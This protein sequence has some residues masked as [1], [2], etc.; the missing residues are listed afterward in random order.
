MGSSRGGGGRG[1]RTRVLLYLSLLWVAGGGDHCSHRPASFWASLLGMDDPTGAGSRAIRSTWTA[2][3]D[4]GFVSIESGAVS[5]DVPTI[6]PLRED[7][8]GRDYTIPAGSDGDTYRRIPQVA[9]RILFCDPDLSGPGLVTFLAMIRTHDQHRG[10]YLVL[11]RAY[12]RGE[13]GMGDSTRKAGLRNL[14]DLGVL[15]TE[16]RSTETGPAG[17]RRRGRTQYS[18]LDSYAPPR[19]EP[20]VPAP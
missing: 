12:F 15:T 8:S 17:E 9:W 1:G 11:P 14:V 20:R 6:R 13:Y 16:G 4:R 5:G 10:E 19:P 3:S 7:G 2:L 18:L